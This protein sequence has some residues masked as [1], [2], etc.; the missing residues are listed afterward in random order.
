MNQ[1]T[2]QPNE[3]ISDGQE[4]IDWLKGKLKSYTLLR[5]CSSGIPEIMPTSPGLTSTKASAEND[6]AVDMK[7]DRTRLRRRCRELAISA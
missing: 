1:I 6:L 2:K 5:R 3:E 7:T 4:Q